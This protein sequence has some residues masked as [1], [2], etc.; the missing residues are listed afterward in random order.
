MADFTPINTQ[1]EFNAAIADRLKRERE[2]AVKPY[3]D[4]AQIKTDLGAAQKT[5][6]ERDSTIADLNTQLKSAR[7][8]LAKTR[9]ALEKHL[10]MELAIRLNG[11]TEDELRSD[12]DSLSQLL[13]SRRTVEPGRST[14]KDSIIGGK[15][16]R[17]DTASLREVLNNMNIGGI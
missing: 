14:E 4:Y 17:F 1:E 11:E 5:L 6:G 15:T 2:N 16:G 7:S 10:P 8:D 12:A 9:I 3:A 13:G